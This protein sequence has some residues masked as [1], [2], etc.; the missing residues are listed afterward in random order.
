MAN[1]MKMTDMTATM[2]MKLELGNYWMHASFESKMGKEP[3]QFESF[4]TFDAASKKW[5]RVMVETGGGWLSGESAGSR[6]A[7][8]TGRWP[9][10]R[11]WARDVSRSRGPD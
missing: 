10:T 3:F 11:Q 9:R 1:S 8:S 5:K 2:K 7:R 6:M 4:T